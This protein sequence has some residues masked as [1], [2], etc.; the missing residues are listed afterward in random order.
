MELIL[1]L[2]PSE[3]SWCS[4]SSS[5]VLSLGSLTAEHHPNLI[6]TRPKELVRNGQVTIGPHTPHLFQLGP[7]EKEL[8]LYCAATKQSAFPP[9]F[10]GGCGAHS[11]ADLCSHSEAMKQWESVPLLLPGSIRG[12]WY[13]AVHKHPSGPYA[14]HQPRGSLQER[15]DYIGS[16][17]ITCLQNVQ[18]I[19][20]DDLSY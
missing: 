10:L 18:D 6:A 20:K 11:R 3:N 1:H 8:Q 7:V 12:A 2:L 5:R 15:E 19:T 14:T 17:L 4:D 9:L 16:R 13:K